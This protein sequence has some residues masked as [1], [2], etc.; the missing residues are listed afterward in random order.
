MASRA[1]SIV[2]DSM[3]VWT[4]ALSECVDSVDSMESVRSM[5]TY[6]S[7]SNGAG[8]PSLEFAELLLTVWDWSVSIWDLAIDYSSLGVF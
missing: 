1:N 2:W 8:T 3:S 6:K 4:S 5:S 7:W